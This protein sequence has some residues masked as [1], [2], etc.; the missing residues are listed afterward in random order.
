[1]DGFK[2]MP[3]MKC[4]GS[5]KM[6][7]KRGGGHMGMNKQGISCHKTGGM[8]KH[9]DAAADKKMVKGMVKKSCMK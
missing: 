5:V 7:K 9:T 6:A 1:M 8:P 4:G 3:K 2:A